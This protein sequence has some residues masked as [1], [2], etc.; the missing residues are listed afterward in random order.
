ML[1]GDVLCRRKFVDEKYFASQYFLD[2]GRVNTRRGTVELHA[3][4]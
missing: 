1:Y 4:F 3:D 2:V